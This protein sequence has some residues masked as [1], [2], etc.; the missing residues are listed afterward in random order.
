MCATATGLNMVACDEFTAGPVFRPRFDKKA[1]TEVKFDATHSAAWSFWIDATQALFLVWDVD[2]NQYGHFRT[3][4]IGVDD[5]GVVKKK[6]TARTELPAFFGEIAVRGPNSNDIWS[7]YG[8]EDA[9]EV[10]S[11]GNIVN[12]PRE[13]KLYPQR[14]D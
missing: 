13:V 7:S 1:I 12:K 11:E 9:D 4:L 8:Y 2:H 14:D 3:F 5:Q 6:Y 10:D